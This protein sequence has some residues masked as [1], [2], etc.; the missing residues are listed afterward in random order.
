MV[1]HAGFPSAGAYAIAAIADRGLSAYSS[2]TVLSE[3]IVPSDWSVNKV[4][5]TTM[6]LSGD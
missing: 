6:P 2:H 3:L 1:I 5:L 4:L